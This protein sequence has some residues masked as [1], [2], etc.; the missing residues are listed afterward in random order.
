MIRKKGLYNYINLMRIT[1]KAVCTNHYSIIGM[2]GNHIIRHLFDIFFR[3]VKINF[4]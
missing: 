1:C 3:K 2:L 4:T